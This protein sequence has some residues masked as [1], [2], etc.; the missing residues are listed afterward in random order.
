[1]LTGDETVVATRV[2]GARTTIVADTAAA[3]LVG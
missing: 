2:L 3:A 1:M